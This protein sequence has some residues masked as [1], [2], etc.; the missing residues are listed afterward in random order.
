MH[1]TGALACEGSWLGPSV[2]ALQQFLGNRH[3]LEVDQRP[4]DLSEISSVQLTFGPG[5]MT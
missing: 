3:V 2:V 1:P 4:I 5:L